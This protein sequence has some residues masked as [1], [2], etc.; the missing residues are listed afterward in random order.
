MAPAEGSRDLH[1]RYSGT[2]I[3]RIEGPLNPEG[4]RAQG[5]R[6]ASEGFP[7]QSVPLSDVKTLGKKL[8]PGIST[9]PSCSVIWSQTFPEPSLPKGR[10]SRIENSRFQVGRNG[11]A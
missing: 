4:E 6:T 3:A 10:G 7:C 5:I 11:L 2:G 8:L 9:M 1:R